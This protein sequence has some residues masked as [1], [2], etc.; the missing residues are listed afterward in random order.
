MI[1]IEVTFFLNIAKRFIAFAEVEYDNIEDA[2][3]L[4]DKGV[5]L[6]ETKDH[7]GPVPFGRVPIHH[8]TVVELN[9]HINNMSYRSSMMCRKCLRRIDVEQVGFIVIKDGEELHEECAL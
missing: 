1:S 6:P 8:K 5:V 7:T 3:L 2:N 4:K 9:G